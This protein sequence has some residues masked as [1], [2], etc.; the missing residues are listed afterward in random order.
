MKVDDPQI[1]SGSWG[2]VIKSTNDI[3]QHQDLRK[4]GDEIRSST[5][6]NDPVDSLKAIAKIAGVNAQK[7]TIEEKRRRTEET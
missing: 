5:G 1:G 4:V 2:K 3:V 6:W 7:V